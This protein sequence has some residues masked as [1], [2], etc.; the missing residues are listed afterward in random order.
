MESQRRGTP[1]ESQGRGAPVESQGR[2]T[3]APKRLSVIM[4]EQATEEEQE[5]A[6]KPELEKV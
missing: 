4:P 1:V 3:S 5:N 2:N 6:M